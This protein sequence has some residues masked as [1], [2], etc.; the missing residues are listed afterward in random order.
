MYVMFSLSEDNDFF[1]N[2]LLPAYLCSSKVLLPLVLFV[3][4]FLFHA[5]GSPS[6]SASLGNVSILRSPL[7]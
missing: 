6:V 2:F 5:G 7:G 4:G 3:F 1:L